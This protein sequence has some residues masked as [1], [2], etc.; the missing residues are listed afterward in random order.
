MNIALYSL[1]GQKQLDLYVVKHDKARVNIKYN[2]KQQYLGKQKL[3]GLQNIIDERPVPLDLGRILWIPFYGLLV[4]N[5]V[6]YCYIHHDPSGSNG[7]VGN[8]QLI[9]KGPEFL[10]NY[11]PP[12][13]FVG[14]CGLRQG[15]TKHKLWTFIS[16]MGILFIPH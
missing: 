12:N 11:P 15:I 7:N 4:H 6:I 1:L 9:N 2:D 16:D 10:L 13:E 5:D 14:D 3:L 8:C